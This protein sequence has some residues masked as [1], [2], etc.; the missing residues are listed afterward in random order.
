MMRLS[1]S[2]MSLQ[3]L[4]TLCDRM[5]HSLPSSSVHG[6][7]QARILEAS[8]PALL[9]GIFPT[10]GSNPGFLHLL[11]W[12]AGSLPL[13]YPSVSQWAFQAGSVSLTCH[14]HFV[15][16]C[17]LK[18]MQTWELQVKFYLGQ[19]ENCRPEGSSSHSSE[20]LLQRGSGGRPIYK[21]WVK[22]EFN[23]I[24]HSF[25]KRFSVSHKDLMSSMKRFSAFLDMR[26]YKDWDHKISSSKY[27]NI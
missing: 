16:W 14:H 4:L 13:A 27:P 3:S 26:R 11:H 2:C 8:G 25:Y 7:L 15:F 1:Q 17:R 23:T 19:N 12:Q 9:Q 10:Q 21:V 5:G 18:K 24:K 20:R 6:I 22:Q